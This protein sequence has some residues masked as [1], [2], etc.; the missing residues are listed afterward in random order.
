MSYTNSPPKY[1]TTLIHKTTPPFFSRMTNGKSL[2]SNHLIVTGRASILTSSSISITTG[3]TIV[4]L[5]LKNLLR[6]RGRLYKAAR[7][8]CRRAIWPTQ[9]FTWYNS[10]GSVSRRVSMRWSCA[11]TTL[12]VTPPAEEK[13]ADVDR[14]EKA[15][16]V[17]VSV[18]GCFSQ[19][20]ASL[21][22]MVAALMA[23][24]TV[25]WGDSR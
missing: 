20:W 18:R 25:K 12:K 24:I 9:V 23:H 4:V 16:G 19:S 5:I 22:L 11:M 13:G 14:V 10:V 17:T 6:R 15:G 1:M 2:R 7:R 21:Y 3:V 8:A